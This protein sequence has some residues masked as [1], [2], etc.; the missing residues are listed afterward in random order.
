MPGAG[1]TTIGKLLARRLDLKFADVDEA[2]EQLAGDSITTLFERQGEVEFRERESRALAELVAGGPSVVATGGGSIL[3]P[4]NRAL[5]VR[6]TV[7]VY[8]FATV[9]ELWR[10]VRTNSKRPLLRV[11]DPFARLCEMFDQRHPL[12]CD[13][14]T[15]TVETRNAP[16]QLVANQIVRQLVLRGSP[17]SSRGSTVT[18]P[19]RPTP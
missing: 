19:K 11:Q 3:S 8:L 17:A 4:S 10:R 9:D 7:P 16:A 5:L 12:Y 2:I 13:V 1:K 6:T 14:A 15:I 18:D